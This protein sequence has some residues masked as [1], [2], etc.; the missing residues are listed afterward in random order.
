[1]KNHDLIDRQFL[2]VWGHWLAQDESGIWWVFET[3]PNQ[4]HSFWYENEVGRCLK[5]AE[6]D[7]NPDW[8]NSLI[9]LD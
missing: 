6:A 5:I 9:R 4:G 3:E 8:Q 7:P 1:M 2:P